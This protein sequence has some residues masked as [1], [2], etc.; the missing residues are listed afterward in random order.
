MQKQDAQV[1]HNLLLF[2]PK[3]LHLRSIWCDKV[4]H[5]LTP[6][7]ASWHLSA[8]AERRLIL[9]PHSLLK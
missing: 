5:I 4:L 7:M 8:R 9:T 3:K 1:S 6:S 2:S